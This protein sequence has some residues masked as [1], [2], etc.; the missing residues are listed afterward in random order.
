[1]SEKNFGESGADKKNVEFV[2][3]HLY[4][5]REEKAVK[6]IQKSSSENILRCLSVV[7]NHFREF[8][9]GS[10]HEEECTGSIARIGLC[11][12]SCIIWLWNK[13]GNRR[14]YEI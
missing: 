13:K 3:F 8:L 6:K 9:G 1:M 11:F 10:C 12:T 4:I 14:R 2:G 5:A 7:K